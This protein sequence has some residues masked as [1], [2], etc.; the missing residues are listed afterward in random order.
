MNPGSLISPNF[1]AETWLVRF[2]DFCTAHTRALASKPDP[3]QLYGQERHAESQS[4][5]QLT[6][7]VG[8]FAVVQKNTDKQCCFCREPV[9]RGK[10]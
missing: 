4:C 2:F 3:R 1:L 7:S 8:K 6:P 9:W 5:P 10:W